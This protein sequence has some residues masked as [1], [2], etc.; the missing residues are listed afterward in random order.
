MFFQRK[1]VKAQMPVCIASKEQIDAAEQFHE[2]LRHR[3]EAALQN[4]Q[5]EVG[6]FYRSGQVMIR[7]SRIE[8]VPAIEVLM[9]T[10]VDENGDHLVIAGHLKSM[11]VM[12]RNVEPLAKGTP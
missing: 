4:T 5:H 3:Y 8:T 6:A 1:L 7:V 11:D 9:L 2:N 12:F 10:G